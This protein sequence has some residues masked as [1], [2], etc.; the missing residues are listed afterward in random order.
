MALIRF[1]NVSKTFSLGG[2]SRLLRSYLGLAVRR[3]KRD[4]FYALRDVTFTVEHG[5]SV[6]I[7]GSNGAGKSTLMS[8]VA[9]LSPPDEGTVEVNGRVAALLELGVGFHSEL[10]GAE[11]VRLNAALMGLSRKR[12]AEVYNDIVEFSGVRDFIDAPIRAYSAGMVLRLAFSVAIHCEPEILLI[13]EVLVVGDQAFQAKCMERIRDF[14]RQGKTL[15]C[16]SHSAEMVRTFC[17]RAIWIDHGRVVRI[18]PAAEVLEAYA[19]GELVPPTN[20]PVETGAAAAEHPED[21]RGAPAG[22]HNVDLRP[23]LDTSPV[24]A[25]RVSSEEEAAIAA[26]HAAGFVWVSAGGRRAGAGEDFE[27]VSPKAAAHDEAAQL[28]RRAAE[29]ARFRPLAPEPGWH[30]DVGWDDPDAIVQERRRIWEYFRQRGVTGPVE[31]T[32]VDGIRAR[33]HLGNDLSRQ[34]FIGGRFEP[35]ELTLVAR[36]LRPGSVMIDAGANEGLFT[37]VAAS[38]VGASGAVLAFEPSAREFARLSDNCRLNRFDHVRLFPAALSDQNGTAE[39][40]IAEAEHGGQNQLAELPEKV[41]LEAS[42]EVQT[43]RLDDAP[44]VAALPRLDLVKID[45]EGAELAVLRGGEAAIRKHRPL[46][47]FECSDD[48]LAKQGGSRAE[49][50]ALLESWGYRIYGFSAATG[51]PIPLCDTVDTLNLIAAPAS[52]Y[53]P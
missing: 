17:D 49:L 36:T 19:R 41:R 53:N 29:L 27:F 14:R 37:L 50:L 26:L 1:Q 11:N 35:N 30:F 5:E 4:P 48:L 43:V 25:I 18:G 32:W 44:G 52:S 22:P 8:L 28:L 15:L 20:V 7:I 46:I 31:V 45:V 10:T 39:L 24:N 9:G 23:L 40:S 47:L 6:A 42:I 13:D 21:E 12:T 51:E 16:V 34:L 2:G 3:P 38:R 33:L